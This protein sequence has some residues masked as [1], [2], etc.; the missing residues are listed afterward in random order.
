MRWVNE[1][2]RLLILS[3][4]RKI[5]KL[6]TEIQK[7]ERIRKNLF[8]QIMAK[9]YDVKVASNSCEVVKLIEQGYEFVTHCADGKT[10]FRK[11]ILPWKV[12]NN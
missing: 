2:L 3:Y 8:E 11:R 12:F 4:Q 7:L 10:I 1:H 9:E 6:K 5:L